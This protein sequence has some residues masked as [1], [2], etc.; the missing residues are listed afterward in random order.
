[1]ATS[2]TDFIIV[3]FY[4]LE[5]F[6]NALFVKK[7]YI[8]LMRHNTTMRFRRLVSIRSSL[9]VQY[10]S[11]SLLG[12]LLCQPWTLPCEFWL[13]RV[14]INCYSSNYTYSIS[15]NC[16]WRMVSG[17]LSLHTVSYL[18]LFAIDILS[19]N[20]VSLLWIFVS[21]NSRC[22]RNPK[23]CG[24]DS[25]LLWQPAVGWIAIRTV[26]CTFEL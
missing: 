17:K 21:G 6:Q 20:F 22:I 16:D 26:R 23:P 13:P 8:L 10:L 18:I 7:F 19:S 15:E 11:C 5:L 4:I 9:R 25:V 14:S 1:M 24:F 12:F 3:R 2:N